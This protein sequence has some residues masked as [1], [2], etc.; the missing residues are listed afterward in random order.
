MEI[1][2][3]RDEDSG[4]PHIYAHG[5]SEREVEQVLRR[6][7]ETRRGRRN[8]RVV[9]GR[10]DAGRFLRVIAVPDPDGSGLFVVTA[11]D[12]QGKPLAALRRR[13]RRRRR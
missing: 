7:L 1:R 4:L 5:V 11:F 13:M 6:P 9:V 12:L 8:S 10:T 2:Y 3:N